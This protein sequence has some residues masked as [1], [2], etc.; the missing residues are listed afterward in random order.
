MLCRG[1]ARPHG[2]QGRLEGGGRHHCGHSEIPSRPRRSPS[3][4]PPAPPVRRCHSAG[5]IGV[6]DVDEGISARARF[7]RRPRPRRRGRSSAC[8]PCAGRSWSLLPDR[9][10]S[11]SVRACRRKDRVRALAG[12]GEGLPSC[13]R[14]RGRRRRACPRFPARSRAVAGLPA[15]GRPRP[16]QV[17]RRLAGQVDGGG[18][19]PGSGSNGRPGSAPCVTT[20]DSA[21]KI[22]SSPAPPASA[23]CRRS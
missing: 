2:A 19:R 14:S 1:S 15:S 23:A 9:I 3:L 10:I 7:C 17:K 8:G 18:L 4:R 12:I 21:S 13:G 20:S 6:V 22:G 11:S 5:G 16:L